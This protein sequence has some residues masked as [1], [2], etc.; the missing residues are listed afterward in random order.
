MAPLDSAG[1]RFPKENGVRTVW[2]PDLDALD[3]ST[4]PGLLSSCYQVHQPYEND[5]RLRCPLQLH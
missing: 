1:K 5:T 3:R 4:A 2:G